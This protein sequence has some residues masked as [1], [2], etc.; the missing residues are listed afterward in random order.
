VAKRNGRSPQEVYSTAKE[1]TGNPTN[2]TG[3][4][5][6]AS[7]NHEEP[8]LGTGLGLKT[9]S[10]IAPQLG[11]TTEEALGRLRAEKFEAEP[12]DTI[13]T[14]AS[15]RSMKPFEV[16]ALLKGTKQ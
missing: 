14:I 16:V 2:L 8:G 12:Q 4:S 6:G 13:R 9:L 1:V 15:R 11:L 10:E 5:P 7:G 3:S